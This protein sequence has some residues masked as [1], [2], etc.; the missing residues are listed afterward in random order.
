MKAAQWNSVNGFG[1][2]HMASQPAGCEGTLS[3]TNHIHIDSATM[4]DCCKRC[5]RLAAC[6][7]VIYPCNL[8]NIAVFELIV[9]KG[10]MINLQDVCAQEYIVYV[11]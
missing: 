4:E 1:G 5:L 2:L 7:P 10:L 9:V 3:P 6:V 11:C 8:C